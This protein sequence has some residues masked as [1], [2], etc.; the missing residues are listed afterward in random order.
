MS[1]SHLDETSESAR[2]ASSKPADISR[3]RG[4]F[5]ERYSAGVR[6]TM[7]VRL[8]A[9]RASDNPPPD[10]IKGGLRHRFQG[11]PCLRTPGSLHHNASASASADGPTSP[12]ATTSIRPAF[13]IRRN[14]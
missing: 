7:L 12:G 10:A 5:I 6:E 1:L 11:L 14:S 13:H 8:G 9:A 2:W 4:A 3:W